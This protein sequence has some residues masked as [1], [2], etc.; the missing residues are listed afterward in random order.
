MRDEEEE[1]PATGSA[2][3]THAR[4]LMG[5]TGEKTPQVES[6]P[7]EIFALRFFPAAGLAPSSITFDAPPG[8]AS[9]E[10]R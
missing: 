5:T 8:S 1:D 4:I 6:F 7:R 2:A 9:D 10:K 3:A